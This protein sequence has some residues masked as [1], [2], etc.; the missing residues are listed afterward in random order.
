MGL[1]LFA[2]TVV[3]IFASYKKASIKAR[4]Y[5]FTSGDKKKKIMLASP[6]YA[7]LPS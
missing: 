5:P 2:N 4:A 1:A 3:S 6:N 7:G